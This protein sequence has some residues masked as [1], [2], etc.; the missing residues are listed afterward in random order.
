MYSRQDLNFIWKRTCGYRWRPKTINVNRELTQSL[1]DES[2]T[3]QCHFRWHWHTR[4]THKRFIS[5]FPAH[6]IQCNTDIN[7]SIHTCQSVYLSWVNTLR[8][9]IWGYREQVMS[10]LFFFLQYSKAEKFPLLQTSTCE[11]K[12]KPLFLIKIKVKNKNMLTL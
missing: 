9:K 10:C 7:V 12:G 2:T 8:E 3:H 1:S 5:V 11:T 6:Y 4:M